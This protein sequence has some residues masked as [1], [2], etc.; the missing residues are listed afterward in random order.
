MG[1]IQV[2][3]IVKTYYLYQYKLQKIYYFIM[4]KIDRYNYSLFRAMYIQ[5][6]SKL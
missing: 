6:C 3:Y 4:S 1:Y 5:N 2:L